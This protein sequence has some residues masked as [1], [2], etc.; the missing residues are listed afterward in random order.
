MNLGDLDIASRVVRRFHHDLVDRSVTA[1][2]SNQ[3]RSSQLR[4]RQTSLF[5]VGRRLA[6]VSQE[7]TPRG[8][9]RRAEHLADSPDSAQPPTSMPRPSVG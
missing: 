5:E 3:T 7:K 1:Y 9:K 4:L 8:Q 6:D 2:G